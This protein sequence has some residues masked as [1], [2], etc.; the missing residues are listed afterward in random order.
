M[1]GMRLASSWA[2]GPLAIGLAGCVS[3]SFQ[4]AQLDRGAQA[5][6]VIPAVA[7]NAAYAEYRIGALDKLDVVIFQEPDLSLKGVEV[8]TAG[9][10]TMPLIG[11]VM[12]AG[13]TGAELSKQ[14]GDLYS[15]KYLNN[16]QVA[17]SIAQSVSQRLVIQG[18]VTQ[19]GVYDIKGSATLLEAISMAKGE[20]RTATTRQVAVFRTINGERAG[21]L[22]DIAAIRRGEAD[23]PQLLGND[24]VVVGTSA[25]KSLWRD[26]LAAAP[27]INVFRPL[28]Y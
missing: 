24:V 28:G 27:L 20:T 9:Q 12:A 5:Y 6:K 21:A 18:E 13:K 23:D 17:V 22:F 8:N 14:I 3:S 1:G 11:D 19:P 7:G 15:V 25:S 26:V 10:I 2:I 16:P 4:D